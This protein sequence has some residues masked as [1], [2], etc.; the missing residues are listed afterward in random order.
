MKRVLYPK[1]KEL[2]VCPK[3]RGEGSICVSCLKP[4]DM[5]GCED[6]GI[7]AHPHSEFCHECGGEG[8]VKVQT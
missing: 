7:P 4:T 8:I 1:Y 5:P 3:C 6:C 2:A